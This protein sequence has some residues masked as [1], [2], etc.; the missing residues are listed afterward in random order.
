MIPKG[1]WKEEAIRHN[2]S[3]L[4]ERIYNWAQ[5]HSVASLEDCFGITARDKASIVKELRGYTSQESWERLVVPKLLVQA[6]LAKRIFETLFAN[7]FFAFRN[8]DGNGS[9]QEQDD[10]MKIYRSMLQINESQGHIWRS[11]TLLELWRMTFKS[12]PNSLQGRFD[13]MSQEFAAN[14][15]SS[16]VGGLLCRRKK[17][18]VIASRTMELQFLYMMAAYL[19]L[20]LWTL[21]SHIVC[22]SQGDAPDARVFDVGDPVMRAHQLHRLDEGDHKLDGKQIVL[23]VQPAVLAYGSNDAE[24]YDQYRVWAPAIVFVEGR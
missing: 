12:H 4:G 7:P 6:L 22:Q 21:R 3:H 18:S 9:L 1:H 13:K 10:L 16:P 17:A 24:H 23:F 11:Q 5:R 19:A 15:V 2:I 14:F 20:G 8:V